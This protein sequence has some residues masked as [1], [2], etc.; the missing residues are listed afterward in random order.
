VDKKASLQLLFFSDS[1]RHCHG[2][3]P[4]ASTEKLAPFD[5]LLTGDAGLDV[6]SVLD[7]GKLFQKAILE[8]VLSDAV[9]QFTSKNDQVLGSA[10]RLLTGVAECFCARMSDSSWQLD[11]PVELAASPTVRIETFVLITNLAPSGLIETLPGG[12]RAHRCDVNC[13]SPLTATAPAQSVHCLT[14]IETAVRSPC[15]LEFRCRRS[16]F[17]DQMARLCGVIHSDS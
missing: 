10:I 7:C 9:Q 12:P 2:V 6:A 13:E 14:A 17:A 4:I 15:V 11:C 3:K 5:L 8:T 16:R 1:P